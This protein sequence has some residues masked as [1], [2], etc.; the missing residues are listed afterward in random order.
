MKR[1][2]VTA[3]FLSCALIAPA[4]DPP[5]DTTEIVVVL[6]RSGSMEPVADDTVGAF[7]QFVH[8]QRAFGG[9][10]H[11]RNLSV[12]LFNTDVETWYS[13]SLYEV[14]RL[15]RDAYAPAG[16]TALLD[17]LGNAITDL[18]E[19]LDEL[20]CGH[21]RDDKVV[22]VVL[23]DGLEN[24]SLEYSLSMIQHMIE[25]QRE[26]HGWQFV[27]L[28]A[29]PDVFAEAPNMG[30]DVGMTINVDTGSITDALS[31]TSDA[32]TGW[33]ETDA[34]IEFTDEQRDAVA[35]DEDD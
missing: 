13:G 6:D 22:F 8:S 18:D 11:D 20:Y 2:L 25:T 5:T 33:I 17:A 14:A 26:E 15:T 27:F 1:I 3:L 21:E 30:F 12:V 31:I 19:R 10:W 35:P 34:T 9:A 16:Y 29:D 28:A 7:N 23:T 24:S 32:L 4:H